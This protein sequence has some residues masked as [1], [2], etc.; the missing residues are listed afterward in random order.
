MWSNSSH[1]R[2]LDLLQSQPICLPCM[3]NFWSLGWGE[4]YLTSRQQD[5]HRPFHHLC[6]VEI[7][8]VGHI[9]NLKICKGL[10]GTSFCV[11][12]IILLF[13]FPPDFRHCSNPGSSIFSRKASCH[14]V[15]CSGFYFTLCWF[16]ATKYYL[17]WGLILNL[18]VRLFHF[19]H[20]HSC[21]DVHISVCK[22]VNGE[23]SGKG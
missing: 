17:Y 5:C 21:M 1:H 6:L 15:I 14:I 19:T 12:L 20:V 18:S 8:K 23:L 7:T 4:I 22:K 2:I 11:I 3:L 16:A 13:L 10:S 9:S